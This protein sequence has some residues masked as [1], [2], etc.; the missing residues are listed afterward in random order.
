MATQDHIHLA[1]TLQE[2]GELAP[3][4]KWTASD[5]LEIPRFTVSLMYDLEGVLHPHVL[6][7][8]SA[9]PILYEDFQYTLKVVA[10]DTYTLTE[11]R[12]QIKAMQGRTVYLVDHDHC[13]DNADH[14]SYIKTMFCEEV[15]P[16]KVFNQQLD[17]FYVDIKL[18]DHHVT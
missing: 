10:E 17:R 13:D 9:N 16:F 2:D 15:G 8:G 7:D 6:L 11:R 4:Y 18:R 3:V 5:R 14:T 12:T 1:T